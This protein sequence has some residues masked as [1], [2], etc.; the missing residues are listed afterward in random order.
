MYVYEVKKICLLT[1]QLTSPVYTSAHAL[2]QKRYVQCF[3]HKQ[4][5]QTTWMDSHA[6]QEL[7]KTHKPYQFMHCFKN[8]CTSS[9]NPGPWM[10]LSRE[11]D[12]CP[13]P[14]TTA[15]F[16]VCSENGLLP[17]SISTNVAPTLLCSM[18]MGNIDSS[19]STDA[20]TDFGD[21]NTFFFW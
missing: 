6:M 11:R 18:Y 1:S 21:S 10:S 7:T 19:N 9:E 16:S 5:R 13:S 2:S 12:C 3:T 8:I 4:K 17:V 20:L 14:N 15:I